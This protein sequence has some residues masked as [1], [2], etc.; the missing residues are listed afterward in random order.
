MSS[1]AR[2]T[3]ERMTEAAQQCT[4][5]EG[6][7]AFFG[8]RPY[9]RLHR[10]LF[11]R[12]AHFDIDVSHFRRREYR[13]SAPRP[14]ETSLREAVSAS[15][16]V[17]GTLR[18]L[19]K[20]NSSRQRDL[21]RQWTADDGIS[22]SHFLGQAH[23]R[24]KTGA[25]PRRAPDQILVKHSGTRRTKTVMLRRA[26]REI[27]VPEVC[28]SCGTGPVWRGKPMTLEVDHINGDW[29][30]DRRDNL[31]LLCPNCHATTRT[32]CRGGSHRSKR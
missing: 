11:E 24:G 15:F 6:V 14:S 2:Y 26:L 4:D 28:G 27:G 31:R 7:I 21:L 16:S 12:F 19:G 30:D 29:T 1:S 17:A 9:G 22:T 23:Q 32:W 10:Y 20:P 8:T 5:I 3:K 25:T 13:R 18:R